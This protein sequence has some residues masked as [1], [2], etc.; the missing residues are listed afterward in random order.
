MAQV[1]RRLWLAVVAGAV[2]VVVLVG[3]GFFL[4][5]Q[6][7]DA[8]VLQIDDWVLTDAQLDQYL[9]DI[10]GNVLYV[11]AREVNGRPIAVPAEGEPFDS[12]LV[13]EVLNDALRFRLGSM[14]LAQRGGTVTAIDREAA[15]KEMAELFTGGAQL[16]AGSGGAG[17]DT[18]DIVLSQFFESRSFYEDGMATMAALRRVLAAEL[19]VEDPDDAQVFDRLAEVLAETAAAATIVVDPAVGRWDPELNAIVVVAPSAGGLEPMAPGE[20]LDTTPSSASP[21]PA[22][23]TAPGESSV[24]G[25]SAVPGEASV[26]GEPSASAAASSSTSAP[27]PAEPSASVAPSAG[28]PGVGP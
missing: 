9:S 12:A 5:A 3:L 28:P 6:D 24:P 20:P 16:S 13:G 4:L 19:G 7:D 10:T 15:A 17:S 8:A 26:P 2:L 22:A 18:L 14:A 25:E 23:P 21:A 27:R 11:Q 1:P